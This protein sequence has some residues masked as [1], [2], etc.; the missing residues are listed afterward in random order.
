MSGYSQLTSY[1]SELRVMQLRMTVKVIPLIEVFNLSKVT[2]GKRFNIR[3]HSMK[4][5]YSPIAR[6]KYASICEA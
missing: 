3:V 6:P 2:Y 4:C 5:D 1:V